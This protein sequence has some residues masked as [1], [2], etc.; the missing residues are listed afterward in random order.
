MRICLIGGLGNQ[1]FQVAQGLAIEKFRGCR[2]FFDSVLLSHPAQTRDLAVSDL[3]PNQLITSSIRMTKSLAATGIFPFNPFVR[4]MRDTRS[5]THV[6]NVDRVRILVGYFQD[7]NL[8]DSVKDMILERFQKST[9]FS[10]FAND[11]VVEQIGVHVRLGDYVSD[12]SARQLHGLSDLGYYLR[13]AE[14]LRDDS[15][16]RTIQIV[17]D[18]P[19][20]AES[21]IA[22]KLRRRNFKVHI[23]GGSRTA[24]QDLAILANS[25][26][27]IC[28][29]STFSWWAGWMASHR[30]NAVVVVPSP[31]FSEASNAESLLFDP[32]WT[33]IEREID[34]LW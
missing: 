29:N 18:N 12:P 17:S 6:I 19:E 7:I 24:K 33:V 31:W 15:G 13:A 11:N 9:S 8:V 1:L 28:A 22:E 14:R 20:I 3:I 25:T 4:V 27:V 30:H 23:R 32:Q 26:H 2:V 10:S 21:L 34:K 16:I 5:V